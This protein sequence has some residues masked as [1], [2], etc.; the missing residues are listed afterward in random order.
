MVLQESKNPVNH[1]DLME[2]LPK[3]NSWDRVTIYRTLSELEEKSII[4][5]LLSNERVTYFEMKEGVH[6]DGHS[7]VVC[8]NCGLIECIDE[9]LNEIPVRKIRGFKVRT[10]DI[11]VRGLCKT[12]Q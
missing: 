5:S 8:D 10:M 3:G 6:A 11:L 12:C 1:A 2:S 7:H 4:R 9:E